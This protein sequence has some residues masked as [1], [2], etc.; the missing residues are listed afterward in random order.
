MADIACADKAAHR[1]FGL[2]C[3]R[4]TGAAHHMAIANGQRSICSEYDVHT[5]GFISFPL[6]TR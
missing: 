5:N 4:Q 3:M 1:A 6:K 2:Q